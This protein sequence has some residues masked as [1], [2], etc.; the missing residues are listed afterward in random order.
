MLVV[1]PA[2]AL[3]FLHP[4]PIDA[5]WGVGERSGEVLRRF[6]LRTVGDVANAPLGQLRGALGE[7][8]AAHLHALAWARDPRRVQTERV[9]KSISAETTFDVD[10]D[11]LDV[12]RRTLLALATRVGA[13]LRSADFQTLHRSRTLDQSTD[14][15]RE[16]FDTAWAL[17]RALAPGQRIR[18][19]GVRVEGLG[20]ADEARQL[21]LGE[22][23]HG[24]RDAERAADAATARFG[25]AAVRPA[26]LLRRTG[27]GR[28]DPGPVEPAHS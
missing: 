25:S 20:T 5:L 28:P 3:E 15:A 7:A 16:V 23:E 11:Q 17:Y 2:T 19:L 9:E 1:P 18:L 12:V 27:E 26:S 14:V 8:A 22:R 10:I 13:R 6:G 4:L 21:L 24:W